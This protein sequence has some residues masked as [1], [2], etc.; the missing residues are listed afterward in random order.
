L[1]HRFTGIEQDPNYVDIAR[2]RIEGWL[3]REQH[4]ATHSTAKD[5]TATGQTESFDR[6]F[7]QS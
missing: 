7:E 5:N 1:G 4:T 6:L 3:S 2:K